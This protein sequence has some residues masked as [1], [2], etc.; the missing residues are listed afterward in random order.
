MFNLQ[1]WYKLHRW[2]SFI[3]AIFFI[4]LC[5]TGLPL[6]FKN[7]IHDLNLQHPQEPHEAISY[8]DIWNYVG[9]GEK[10]I[11]AKH[12]NMDIKAISVQPQEGRMLYRVQDKDNHN[13]VNARLSMG[14]QQI[15]YYPEDSSMDMHHNSAVK[16]P[17]IAKFMHIMHVVHLRLGLSD[18]G[19]IFL[20]TMCLLSFLSVVTGLALYAPFMK[21][22]KFGAINK[23]TSM[24]KWLSWHNFC[25]VITA[26][27]AGILCFT[28]VMIV[29]FSIGYG[30]YIDNTK[31]E[32][33]QNLPATVDVANFP[34]PTAIDY[35]HQQFPDKYILSIDMPDKKTNNS[36]YVFYITNAKERPDEFIGQLVFVGKDTQDNIQNFT[37]PIPLYLQFSAVMLNLHIHNHDI[38]SLQILWAIIDIITIITIIS[39]LML[40]WRKSHNIIYQRSFKPSKTLKSWQIWKIPAYIGILSLIG[41]VA[42]LSQ[43]GMY[44]GLVAWIVAFILGFI[45]W[46]R[47]NK[48]N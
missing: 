46:F 17:F 33:K 38:L 43:S 5:L 25:G 31:L 23:N 8:N 35:I 4:I 7:E 9:D 18:G 36:Q 47:A 3:C 28:G 13:V 22:T 34:L 11:L 32:A 27:W 42:P 29:V 44:I 21:K 39:G 40:W 16:S 20:G 15:S 30:Y 19:M 2:I 1:F 45:Q 48:L 26:C 41:L 14:G 37:Q 10:T 24:N 12:P 6:I